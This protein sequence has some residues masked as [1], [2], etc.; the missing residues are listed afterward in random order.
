MEIDL[1]NTLR[2]RGT[3]YRRFS[4]G[5]D[6]P[7]WFYKSIKSIDPKIHF[8]FH[9]YKVMWD[10]IINQYE[11]TLDNPRFTIHQEYG[12]ENWGFV[13]TGP[14]KAPL[15]ENSWHLWRLCEPYGWAHIVK[16]ESIIPEYLK[17]LVERLDLQAN[18]RTKYGDKAWNKELQDQEEILREKIQKEKQECFDAVNEENIG[19]LKKVMEEF[20]RGNLKPTNPKKEQVISYPGQK[21]RTKTSR[22]LEDHEG[23]LIIPDSW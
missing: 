15:I 8:V 6:L 23:G 22:N 9:P 12:Q 18:F 5:V 20:D 16:V 3:V 11:G 2:P 10:D 4:P 14:D 13:L 1:P 17:T 19:F 21:N 7:S